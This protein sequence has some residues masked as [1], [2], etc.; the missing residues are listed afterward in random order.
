MHDNREL[1]EAR[2]HRELT[3]RLRPAVHRARVPLRVEAW[4][5]PG[6]PVPYD[7][8]A[9]A[10]YEP[11]EVGE[12]WGRPWGTTWFRLSGTVPDTWE[13]WPGQVEAVIDL[14]FRGADAGFQAEGLVWE[15]G[16]P[17]QGVHPR[18]TAVPLPAAARGQAIELMVEAA[19]NPAFPDFRPSPMG[20]WDTAPDRPIYRL[21]GA[22]LAVLDRDVFALVLD[23]E[24]LAGTMFALSLDDPRRQRLLRTLERALDALDL[25]DVSGTA[26]TA[27]DVLA[28]ALALPARASAHRTVA[29]GHAH[30]DTAWLWPAAGDRAQVHPHLRFRAAADGRLPR[31]PVRVLAGG[32]VRVDAAGAPGAVRP[33]AARR[34]SPASGSRSAACGWR[35]TP[36][37]RA[38]SP[39]SASSS[40]GNGSSSSTSAGAAG[41]SGSPTCSATRPRSRR[42]SPPP[43]ATA[44]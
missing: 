17:L 3:E 14:G 24:V 41:R 21:A 11:F 31:L 38:G 19:A 37:S 34:P 36:T 35:R 42:S 33:H 13:A 1:V 15:G 28:P 32:A 9:G 39:S 22:D 10:E 7:V 16:A 26:A 23:I 29:V 12:A 4:S 2:L 30:I 8:A 44:S 18:R 6:E 40:T 20:A 43:G 5:P 25:S 27:R